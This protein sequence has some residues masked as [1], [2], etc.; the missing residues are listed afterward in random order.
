[1]DILITGLQPWDI[2]IGS[3]CKNIAFEL[4]KNHRVLYVNRP[5]DIASIVKHIK[6]P[7]TLT[8][9]KSLFHRKYQLNEVKDNLW[10]LNPHVVLLSIG[11]MDRFQTLY[12]LFLKL[13]SIFYIRDYLT[14]QPYYHRKKLFE[15]KA[16]EFHDVVLA[17]SQ[18][19]CSYSLKFNKD[20]FFVGQGFETEIFLNNLRE[21][22]HL[23]DMSGIPKPII[24]YTGAL[25]SDRLDI[26]I[27]TELAECF[28]NY[29]FVLVGPEDSK[30]ASSRLH[31]LANVYFLGSKPMG[32]IPSYIRKFDVCIN[33]QLLND[34]TIGNYPR[35]IDEYLICGKPVIARRTIAMD[36]FKDVVYLY[37]NLT[38]FMDNVEKA[39]K[40][41]TKK[42]ELRRIN[43]AKRH[44]WEA[45]TEKMVSYF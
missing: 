9:I 2:E 35:K 10:V 1:M 21:F 26:D 4:S 22:S 16:F 45:I 30:F 40:I 6:R 20:S 12:N 15:Q 18:Y 5:L 25:L 41:N 23:S 11:W 39:L 33:P 19:L 13:N 24:G 27:L 37:D 28:T 42:D 38:E 31:S 8:R 7:Q 36:Y 32:D 3:N 14:Y 17:N 34:L 44:T 29:S 43:F